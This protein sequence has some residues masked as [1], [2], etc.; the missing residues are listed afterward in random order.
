M[1]LVKFVITN[2]V[3]MKIKVIA[4]LILLIFTSLNAQSKDEKI[5]SLISNDLIKSN[6]KN[7]I[8]KIVSEI[9][10]ESN[11]KYILALY[12]LKFKEFTGYKQGV[13]DVNI[14]FDS[15]KNTE[16][17]QLLVRKKLFNYLEKLKNIGLISNEQFYFQKERVER[18]DYVD[19]LELLPD[20]VAQVFYDETLAPNKLNSYRKKIN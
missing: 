19:I 11:A 12:Q 2:C 20:L 17:E 9:E 4:I 18:D 15:Y 14:D 13:L 6:Q 3:W 1:L 16:E 7:Q 5:E 10:I 8:K